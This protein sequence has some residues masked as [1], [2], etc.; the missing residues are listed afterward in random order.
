MR[1]PRFVGCQCPPLARTAV[2]IWIN[3][4]QPHAA[5]RPGNGDGVRAALRPL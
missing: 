2:L 1:A 3:A 5:P 4:A